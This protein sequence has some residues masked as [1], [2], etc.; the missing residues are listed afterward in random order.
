MTSVAR[1]RS[2]KQAS[3]TEDG[4]LCGVRAEELSWS[5]SALRVSQFSVGDSHGKLVVVEELKVGLCRLNVWFEDFM[6]AVAQWYLECDS[7]NSCVKIRCQ[8]TD[9][10]NFAEE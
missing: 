3:L 6:C 10:E 7:Y 5:Q 2:Y 4:V 8:E 1:R 9:R